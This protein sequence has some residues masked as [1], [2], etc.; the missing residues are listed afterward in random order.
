MVLRVPNDYDG[1]ARCPACT[2]VFVVK[3][4]DLPIEEDEEL[5][6]ED[7]EE[8]AEIVDIP[9]PVKT[10]KKSKNEIKENSVEVKSDSKKAQSNDDK[11]NSLLMIQPRCSSMTK[12]KIC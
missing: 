3:P 11:L 5:V 12:K 1:Q 4:M 6:D 2:H 10:P 8:A 9:K 7:I